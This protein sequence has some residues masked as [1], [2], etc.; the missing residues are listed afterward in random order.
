[1]ETLGPE[2]WNCD[3]PLVA[4]RFNLCAI[5]AIQPMLAPP[6][7]PGPQPEVDEEA[8]DDVSI[9][10][11]VESAKPRLDELAEWQL[12]V[13]EQSI[14]EGTFFD[15]LFVETK[16]LNEAVEIIGKRHRGE[17]ICDPRESLDGW[18]ACLGD[19]EP[20]SGETEVL[21]GGDIPSQEPVRGILP[22]HATPSQRN[23]EAA[24][25]EAALIVRARKC[26]LASAIKDVRD[27]AV[28][29]NRDDESIDRAIRGA[30]NLMY[31]KH[32]HPQAIRN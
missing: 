23:H 29:N 15:P 3:R 20:A 27:L 4:V 12:A 16:H 22:A 9:P 11:H 24:A 13:L 6:P 17:A 7:Q 25:H 1:M 2:L 14:Y 18:Q 8:D 32:G 28:R 30:Y 5:N 10:E 19:L 26:S 31:D 21:C